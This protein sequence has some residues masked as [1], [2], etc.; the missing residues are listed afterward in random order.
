MGAFEFDIT[1][2]RALEADLNGAGD[3]IFGQV[4]AT[5]RKAALN[6][7]NTLRDQAQG[8]RHAPA[9]PSSITFDARTG[10]SWVEAEIGPR[11]GGA[12]SLALLY[13]GN[14]KSGPRLPDPMGALDAEEPAYLEHLAQ[15]AAQEMLP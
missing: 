13:F 7:K 6:V 10:V 4:D 8:V 15:V 3:R 12:G 9:F 14:S 5:T 2:L 1:D 11:E